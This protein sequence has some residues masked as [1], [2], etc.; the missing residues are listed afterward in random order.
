MTDDSLE[1]IRPGPGVEI[2]GPFLPEYR[3]TLDG[4][5]VPFL[6][7]H[8]V[9]NDEFSLTID[10]RFGIHKPV[11]KDE[12]DNWMPILANAM[13]VAAG[14]PCFGADTKKMNPFNVRMSSLGSIEPAKPALAVVDGGLQDERRT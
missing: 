14:Y 7:V 6:T 9:G 11:T 13:A 10:R 4:Y 8:P 12:L 3:V 5:R 2:H 1:V